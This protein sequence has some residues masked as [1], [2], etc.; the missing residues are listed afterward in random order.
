MRQ[1]TFFKEREWDEECPE[2]GEERERGRIQG[3]E[4]PEIKRKKNL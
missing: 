3:E 4:S 1:R 2:N